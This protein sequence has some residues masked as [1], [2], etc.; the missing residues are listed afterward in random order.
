M[1]SCDSAA[2][3]KTTSDPAD[4]L[5]VPGALCLDVLL[6][7]VRHA[8]DL[9]QRELAAAAGVHHSVVSRIEALTVMAPAFPTVLR[10][11]SAAGCRLVAVTGDGRPVPPWSGEPA[12]N[13]GYRHWPA[14][15]DVRRVLNEDDWWYGMFLTDMRPLPSHTVDGRRRRDGRR[16]M[17]G[18]RAADAR[19]DGLP[20]NTPPTA[21]MNGAEGA[22]G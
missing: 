3:T 2:T 8:A 14:H 7:A 17:A 22:P 16:W 6:R 20:P 18:L 13:A 1:D 12:L 9:S 11:L 10:L 19:S 4:P 15:L 5:E 21:G